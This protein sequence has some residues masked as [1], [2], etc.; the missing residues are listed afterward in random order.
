MK[1][2]STYGISNMLSSFSRAG[3]AGQKDGGGALLLPQDPGD[4]CDSHPRL[5]SQL[6]HP[7]R[8]R[9]G[10]GV[11]RRQAQ[12]LRRHAHHRRGEWRHFLSS[13]RM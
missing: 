1:R 9:E 3:G 10:D 2:T 8:H 11:L 12:A 13:I 7:P 6:S 4:D 5:G